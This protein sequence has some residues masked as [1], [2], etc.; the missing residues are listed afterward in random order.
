[1]SSVLGS[2]VLPTP[3]AAAMPSIG[4][5]AAC[6]RAPAGVPMDGRTANFPG[7]TPYGRQQGAEL[8]HRSRLRA[9]V[10]DIKRGIA[11]SA[12]P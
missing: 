7:R 9:Q 1:M 11:T 2:Y 6:V 12:A 5:V 8:C 10:I 3:S 4:P